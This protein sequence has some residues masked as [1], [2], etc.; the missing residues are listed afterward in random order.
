[1]TV[2][3]A[4]LMAGCQYPLTLVI[5]NA[6][7]AAATVSVRL[8]APGSPACRAPRGVALMAVADVGRRVGRPDP[9]RDATAT[10]DAA[11]CTV[12]VNV[13]AQMALEL[14]F[15]SHTR[16]RFAERD[17]D[18]LLV[19]QGA[20]GSVRWQGEELRARLVNRSDAWVFEYGTAE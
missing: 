10:F 15:D 19:V 4:L 9:S 18:A 11:T 3:T 2:L 13:S 6:T 5:A 7:G 14:V 16:A 1:L 17:R 8:F 12:R 20:A